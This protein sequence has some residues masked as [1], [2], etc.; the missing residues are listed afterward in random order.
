MIVIALDP[1][2]TTGYSIGQIDENGLMRVVTGENRW[3]HLELWNLF[4]E[5]EPDVIICETFEYR[6]RSRKGLELYSRELIGVCNLYAQ[7]KQCHIRMQNPLKDNESTF[8]N[9]A[10]LQKDN[11]YKK[12]CGHANDA[13]RHLLTWFVFREGFQYNKKGYESAVHAD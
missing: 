13:A 3:S 2:I 11:I 7:M 6:N 8:F 10:R 12:G 4:E 5:Y 1:G 9:D